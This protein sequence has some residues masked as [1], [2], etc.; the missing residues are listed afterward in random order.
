M[1]GGQRW[2][3]WYWMDVKGQVYDMH[4]GAWLMAESSQLSSFYKENFTKE[5]RFGP[6]RS[7]IDIKVTNGGQRSS[8]LGQIRCRGSV[9]CGIVWY[10]QLVTFSIFIDKPQAVSLNFLVARIVSGSDGVEILLRAE[11]LKPSLEGRNKKTGIDSCLKEN[12]IKRTLKVVHGGWVSP[13]WRQSF[14]VFSYVW[15]FL[16][17]M[18]EILT[19]SSEDRNEKTVIGSCLDFWWVQELW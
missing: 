18:E 15:F 7:K 17:E 4:V 3:F 11:I 12:D 5:S 6:F 16:A 13:S 9:L 1:N 8:I 19:P 2:R 10:L 14:P